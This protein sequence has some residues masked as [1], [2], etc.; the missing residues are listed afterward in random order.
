MWPKLLGVILVV[1]SC[2]GLGADA[3]IRM[4]RRLR[5]L[6]QLKVMAHHLK[7]EILYANAPLPE[8]F[9]RTGKRNPGNAGSLFLAVAAELK[10]ETGNSFDSIWKEQAGQFS[11]KSVLSKKEQAALL[12]FGEHL[13]YL[14]R[15]MQEKTILFYLEDLERA[16]TILRGQ[17]EEKS[18]L[19]ISMGIMAGLF[20][21]VVMI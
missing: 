10:K 8:A 20:L 1:V 14:D 18:R 17:E 11:K 19:Y 7:G 3:V 6:E 15:D 4:K 13:G 16:I 9:E 12:R 5:L 21:A 2:A